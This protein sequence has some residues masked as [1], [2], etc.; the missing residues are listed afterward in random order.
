MQE[1]FLKENKDKYTLKNKTFIYKN[2]DVK[3]KLEELK[4]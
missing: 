1:E 4:N 2:D 3:N